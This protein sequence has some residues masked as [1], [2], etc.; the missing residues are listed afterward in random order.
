MWKQVFGLWCFFLNLYIYIFIHFTVYC[1]SCL[2]RLGSYWLQN[3]I[4]RHNFGYVAYLYEFLLQS[5]LD[6][7]KWFLIV[8]L[9]QIRLFPNLVSH[10]R[11]GSGCGLWSWWRQCGWLQ[12][13]VVANLNSKLC[14]FHVII[15]LFRL[16]G[17]CVFANE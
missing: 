14:C 6:C 1:Q 15:A 8:G 13:E 17:A 5:F 2:D 11:P 16:V 12:K 9:S 3:Q 7:F 4:V 10:R